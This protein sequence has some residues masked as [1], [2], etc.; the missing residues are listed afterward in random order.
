MKLVV[1]ITLAILLASCG[2]SRYYALTQDELSKYFD[3]QTKPKDKIEGIWRGDYIYSETSLNYEL[4]KFKDFKIAIIKDIEN[5]NI[6][7]LISLED[8]D[9]VRKYGSNDPMKK[10]TTNWKNRIIAKIL[11][12]ENEYVAIFDF[13]E[14]TPVYLADGKSI[15]KSLILTTDKEENERNKERSS[16]ADQLI[17]S[18]NK[19]KSNSNT[20]HSLEFYRQYP[21]YFSPRI[22]FELIN[23]QN[24]TVDNK[25]KDIEAVINSG[26]NINVLDES[27]M[28]LLHH[29]VKNC[30]YDLTKYFLEKK[31]N[32]NLETEP[33]KAT[34]IMFISDTKEDCNKKRILDLLLENGAD[35]NRMNSGGY[36]TL[37][38]LYNERTS[39]AVLYYSEENKNIINQKYSAIEQYLIEK[40]ADSKGLDSLYQINID[41]W[42]ILE[43]ENNVREEERRK[44]QEQKEKERLAKAKEIERKRKSLTK[45]DREKIVIQIST[46]KSEIVDLKSQ[47]K[48]YQEENKKYIDLSTKIEN[49]KL[50]SFNSLSASEKHQLNTLI[51]EYKEKAR[52]AA[53]SVM[54]AQVA[55]QLKEGQLEDLYLLVPE[56][57]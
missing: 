29:L 35:I 34:P 40:G 22:L 23:N 37:M 10:R 25:I 24:I 44:L 49:Q 31:A 20:K 12:N 46:L 36:T 56:L 9:F 41:K 42:K 18:L 17:S 33:Y 19:K 21:K 5:P 4:S 14:Q 53:G 38:F 26:I 13:N 32:P 54:A 48:Y 27:G 57:R 28:G 3:D 15:E 2:S 47:K 11:K 52:N 51:G 7:L 1:F 43:E 39:P 6:F 50:K 45:T 16:A 8:V 55:I 30:D